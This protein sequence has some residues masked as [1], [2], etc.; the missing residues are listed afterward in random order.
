MNKY[1]RGLLIFV[2][3]SVSRLLLPRD[4]LIERILSASPAA[5]FATAQLQADP[6]PARNARV[7][8]IQFESKLVGK[9]LPYNIVLPVDYDKPAAK[10]K[11][12]PV[13]Y[14]L[15]GLTGHYTNWLEKTQLAN[16]AAAMISSSSLRKATT[17]GTPTARLFR[18]TSMN[19][20]SCRS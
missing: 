4:T 8:T 11:R 13:L 3:V 19:P 17:V 7:Q 1:S 12:Y 10:T 18:A 6:A 2:L 14:L 16:Y 5:A 9:T 20:T 15:H